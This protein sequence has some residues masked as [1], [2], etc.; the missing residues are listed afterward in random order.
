MKAPEILTAVE[1]HLDF[2][3][4]GSP[5]TTQDKIDLIA[6]FRTPEMEGFVGLQSPPQARLHH[7]FGK[8]SLVWT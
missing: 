6:L 8:D 5:V 2:D 4:Y 3:R 7:A 1:A